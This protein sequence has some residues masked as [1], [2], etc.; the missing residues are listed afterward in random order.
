[1]SLRRKPRRVLVPVLAA[2]AFLSAGAPAAPLSLGRRYKDESNGFQ[3]YPPRKWEQVPTKFN[4]T[5]VVG[6]WGGR[7]RRGFFSPELRVLRFLNV[8]SRD[9]GSPR[10]ALKRGIPGYGGMVRSQPKDVWAYV[11]RHYGHHKL[12]VIEEDRDF[13]ARR[14]HRTH[15]KLFQAGGEREGE[16]RENKARLVVCAAQIEREDAND[17]A[18]G[19]VFA[20]TVADKEKML[21]TFKRSVARF[22]I[23]EDDDEEDGAG[24]GDGDASGGNVIVDSTKKPK[25]WREARKKKL[26]PGWGAVDTE[27]Y[28]IIYNK[29]VKRR[30][31]RKIARQIEAIREDVYEKMFPPEKDVTAI[32][33]VRVCK[34]RQEYHRYGGPGGSAGYWSRGDEE[35]VFYQ[36]KS[37]KKDSLRVLYHEAFH[38]YIHYAVGDVAPHSWFNEG[39]GD[40]FAGHN[41]VGGRFK[42]DV[43]RWRTGVISNAIARET[44]VPLEQFLKYSQGQYYANA[45][46]CYAQGWSLVYFLREVER[47]RIRKYK[48]YWGL[49]DK[50]FD[51]IKR[52]VKSVKEKG[53]EGLN[54]R[55]PPRP[56][57]DPEPKGGTDAPL[58]GLPGLDGPF[59]GEHPDAGAAEP[60]DGGSSGRT[61]AGPQ[62]TGVRSA[63]DAAV[64]EA[65]KGIDLEQLEKDWI[66]F[67]K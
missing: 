13:R 28:L 51:A 14:D 61:V 43:F 63:L 64:D 3:V 24:D 45:S 33:V 5:A 46:L 4:E 58:P 56:E 32:S 35:L 26:I 50:Y 49:L 47:R 60:E 15:F 23:L 18:F 9:I 52:N 41:Y 21:L 66:E 54:R 29:E 44:Y 1:M 10:D 12:K 20:T 22:R 6:K 38:Q 48:K 19:V 37:N 67:S 25:A 16:R 42:A 59:P 8:E 57:P 34:D 7:R 40:Y 36:D 55:P 62:I 2:L 39:H 17:A 65:F 27:N 11:Q 30:L 53:L 31:V